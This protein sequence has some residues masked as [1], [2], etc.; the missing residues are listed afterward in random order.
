MHRGTEETKGY[1]Y[2]ADGMFVNLAMMAELPTEKVWFRNIVEKSYSWILDPGPKLKAGIGTGGVH[3]S[4]S[5]RDQKKL[6]T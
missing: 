5:I 4:I 1:L 3:H 6:S 2:I